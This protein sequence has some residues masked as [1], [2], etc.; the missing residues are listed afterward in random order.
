MK[1]GVLLSQVIVRLGVSGETIQRFAREGKIR[2]TKLPSGWKLY[3]EDDVE[4]VRR[5]RA[6]KH[7]H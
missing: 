5:S 7:E 4:K 6:A 2:T 3:N 1:S